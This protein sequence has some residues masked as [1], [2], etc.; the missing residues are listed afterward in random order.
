MAHSPTLSLLAQPSR[1]IILAPT[2]VDMPKTFRNVEVNPHHHR[3][4]LSKLQR[5]RGMT[6]VQDG[7]IDACHLSGDGRHILEEDKLSW[8]IVSTQP[9][10]RVTGCARFRQHSPDATAEDLRAWHSALAQSDSWQA[11]VRLAVE[12]EMAFAK[13]S[14][15]T[16]VEVGGWA[17]ATDHRFT[18]EALRIALSTFALARKLGGCVGITTATVRNCS[19]K[20]LR[21]LGGSELRAR[22]ESLPSYYDPQ[23][24]CQ[25]EILRFHSNTPLPKYQNQL[26]DIMNRLTDLRILCAS[27]SAHRVTVPVEDLPYVA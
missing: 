11:K 18:T 12:D 26:R 7:A 5:L 24:K 8:H 20:I 27:D 23:Y 16:F 25:M 21:R 13:R 3:E 10:G 14:D 17:V 1:L 19:A 2:A 9:D 22:G 6:Y 15:L 4:V